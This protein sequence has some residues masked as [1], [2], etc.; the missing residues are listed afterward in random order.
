MAAKPETPVGGK[1]SEQQSEEWAEVSLAAKV[2]AA[3]S[4]S[5]PIVRYY[6]VGTRLKVIGRESEWVKITDPTS[7]KEGWIY[8]KYLAPID[9]PNQNKSAQAE[10]PNANVA[11]LA[12]PGPYARPYRPRKYGW[13]RYRY[14]APPVGFAIRVYPGW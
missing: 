1:K 4:V 8:E 10:S 12:Q 13:K 5:S 7:S 14:Y 6:R 3:P 11:T 2:H 9:G